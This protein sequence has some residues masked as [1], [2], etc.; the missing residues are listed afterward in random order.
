MPL[1]GIGEANGTLQSM[2]ER[3]ATLANNEGLSTLRTATKLV[4][5]ALVLCFGG[6]VALVAAGMLQAVYA[7]RPT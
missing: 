1:I 7:L 2:A 3:A 4:E 6:L 5:P